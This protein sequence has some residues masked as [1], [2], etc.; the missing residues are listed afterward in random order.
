MRRSE[1]SVRASAR[2]CLL[3]L[4]VGG[5]A[6]ACGVSVDLF[7]DDPTTTSSTGGGGTGG[8]G[9]TPSVAQV[10][11]GNPD[12]GSDCVPEACDVD[13]GP[14][15]LGVC[16]PDGQCTTQ[17]ANPGTPCDDDGVCDESGTCLQGGD[18]APCDGADDCVSGFCVDGVCCEAACDGTCATCAAAGTE[19]QCTP[20]PAGTDP[21]M[22][23]FGGSC[24]GSTA[25]TCATGLTQWGN[26]YGNGFEQRG[27]DVD[28][29]SGNN[30]VVTGYHFG[31]IDFGDGPL[32]S[33]GNRDLFLAKIDPQGNEV[34]SQQFGDASAQF[35]WDV[36]VA[37]NDD[38]IVG[39]YFFGQ[40]DL[41]GSNLISGGQRDAVLAR[42][43]GAGNHL[44]SARFG[45]TQEDL[46]RTVAA[47]PNG[48]M[49]IG[50]Y[51]E[52][53]IDFG[54]G[55]LVSAGDLDTF[56]AVFD[57]AGTH[58]WSDAF[59]AAGEDRIFDLIF[60]A[61]GNLYAS[62]RFEDTVDFGGGPLVSAGGFDA[63]VAKYGPTGTP[64]WSQRYG[65]GDDQFI[66]GLAVDASGDVIFAG[67]G[68]G[69]VDLGGGPL[70]S[71][72]DFDV[73]VAKL[74]G[75]GAHQWSAIYP[76]PESQFTRDLDV[77]PAGNIV[78][79]GYAFGTP[80]FGGGAL[81][82]AGSRDAFVVKLNPDGVHLWSRDFGGGF[83]QY[84]HGIA[85]D[86]TGHVVTTGYF[87]S[88]IN[89][90]SGPVAAGGNED[91]FIMRLA[92]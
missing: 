30:L 39:G 26:V 28:V 17:F 5:A 56:V 89:F 38:I 73:F 42:F 69:T 64:L 47:G 66:R 25:P 24:T 14:C 76:G 16:G 1:S 20:H 85:V 84:G 44:F 32:S 8:D 86:A 45:G 37:P 74:D 48:E 58:V 75:S 43:D 19:G 83:S 34:W 72:D 18:G 52:G 7:S 77:D 46:A 78:F 49:A 79:T 62:G 2:I 59:G 91:V 54:G 61:G 4:I 51:F 63:F 87:A 80:D 33:V 27:H 68:D 11:G 36:M 35:G 41:G 23:C 15:V 53:T 88:T 50:G 82:N 9:G 22:E 67:Y 55:A 90:G 21:E 3:G 29:D 40:V 6:S 13:A 70:T 10:G 65:D 57:A 60:D 71:V 81:A 31:A 92:P 12:G